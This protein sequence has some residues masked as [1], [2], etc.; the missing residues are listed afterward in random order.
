M[1][2]QLA[3][4]QEGLSS[5]RKYTNYF[6]KKKLKYFNQKYPE[7]YWAISKNSLKLFKYAFLD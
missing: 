7:Y 4:S 5:L 6:Q 2:A 1:A 3:A